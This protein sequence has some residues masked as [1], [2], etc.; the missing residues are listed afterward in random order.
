MRPCSSAWRPGLRRPAAAALRPPAAPGWRT[1]P[2]AG[3]RRS[4]RSPRPRTSARSRGEVLVDPAHDLLA[5]R[6][7]DHDQVERLPVLVVVVAD[8]HVVE[9]PAL[10]RWSPASSGSGPD[11]RSPTRRVSRP[12]R[13]SLRTRPLEPQ[14]AHVRD[15]GD[16]AARCAWPGAPRG[17]RCTGP[18]SPSRRTRP[19]A[20]RGQR[21]IRREESL[22]QRP[23]HVVGIRYAMLPSHHDRVQGELSPG[24]T[25]AMPPSERTTSRESAV[26]IGLTAATPGPDSLGSGPARLCAT[27]PWWGSSV[28]RRLAVA[29]FAA[30]PAACVACGG[31]RSRSNEPEIEFATLQVHAGATATRTRSPSRNVFPE[32]WPGQGVR[33][34][35]VAGSSRPPASR[36]GS[37]PPPAIAPL[38]RTV[39]TT[40]RP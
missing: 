37:I 24:G 30:R 12:A 29:L 27:P 38:G 19:S 3:S 1:S 5:I 32:R 8:Q 26:E 2:R 28:A 17:S 15:I 39:R 34:A 13:N 35:V 18:A 23:I 25:A 20:R 4:R 10:A 11:R 33:R 31:R 7:V 14:P 36:R 16:P 9:D 40:R 21:A 22:S 6:G